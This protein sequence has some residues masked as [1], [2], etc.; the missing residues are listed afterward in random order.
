MDYGIIMFL[1]SNLD[2]DV[3]IVDRGASNHIISKL[4]SLH[5]LT[6]FL[7]ANSIHLPNGDVAAITHSGSIFKDQEINDVLH[8]P[9]FV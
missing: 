4:E 1:L 6:L 7:K 2:Q 3:W 5:N 8:V 9:N